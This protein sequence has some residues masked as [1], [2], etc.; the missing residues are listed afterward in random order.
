MKYHKGDTL[1]EVIVAFAV[2]AL[3]AVS[4]VTLM[5]KGI[6]LAQDSL[7]TTLVR[8][9]IDAQADM[10]RYVQSETGGS[11][12]KNI[13]NSKLVPSPIDRQST[14]DGQCQNAPASSFILTANPTS[15]PSVRAVDT[16]SD[17]SYSPASSYSQ[18]DASGKAF[19]IWIQAVRAQTAAGQK[20]AYDMHIRTCWYGLTNGSRP[21]STAT[22][23]RLY[24]N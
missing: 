18:V 13:I 10:L 6:A 23:V 22:I 7:E 14:V 4:S 21:N 8:E 19:G 12:F 5:N 2:F 3:V 15:T 16:N 9:Q 11:T 17:S 24:A 20:Q 1:V